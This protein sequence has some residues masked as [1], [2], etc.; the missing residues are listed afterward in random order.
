M[1]ERPVRVWRLRVLYPLGAFDHGFEPEGWEASPC[2]CRG[3]DCWGHEFRWPRARNYLSERS[4]HQRADLLRSFGA[5][6]FVE[7][8]DPVEWS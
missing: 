5:E 1:S 6:V 7:A 3:D 2:H 4:A 8:S